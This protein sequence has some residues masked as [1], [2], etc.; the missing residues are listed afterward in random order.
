M[1][2]VSLVYGRIG[3][4]ESKKEFA[5][6]ALKYPFSSLLFEMKKEKST[7]ESVSKKGNWKYLSSVY[8]KMIYPRDK[9]LVVL[10]GV[11]GAG[12]STWVKDNGFEKYVLCADTLREMY[13]VPVD[14]ISQEYNSQVWRTMFDMIETRM[15]QG[16]FA[17]IDAVHST[18][19]SIKP[20]KM[21]CDK[22]GYKLKT[23][24][25]KISL[26]DAIERNETREKYKRVPVD[27]IK[28]MH[29]HIINNIDKMEVDNNGP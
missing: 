11:P 13:S 28:R 9:E 19:K 26:E 1:V 21:L 29:N 2:R 10:R 25:F 23:E 27:V 6:E 17:I 18:N 12:K 16:Q 8:D 5:L 14:N 4:I 3:G 22:Y 24:Y 7:W 15:S 20:Y